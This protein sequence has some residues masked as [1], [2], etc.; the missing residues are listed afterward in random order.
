MIAVSMGAATAWRTVAIWTSRAAI[1]G[2][3]FHQE[4][5]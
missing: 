1:H 3:T 2:R 5:S 4:H